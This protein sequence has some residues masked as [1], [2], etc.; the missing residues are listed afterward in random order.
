MGG[1]GLAAAYVSCRH[2]V[3]V[4]EVPNADARRLE[5]FSFNSG[6]NFFVSF[7]SS[8]SPAKPWHRCMRRHYLR[9]TVGTARQ[10]G[11][12]PFY[13]IFFFEIP[14]R[15]RLRTFVRDATQHRESRASLS[16][17]FVIRRGGD[18]VSSAPARRAT[19]VAHQA[20]RPSHAR[21]TKHSAKRAFSIGESILLRP[22]SG[23]SSSTHSR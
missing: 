1:V 2:V 8:F 17:T 23:A 10:P 20:S 9:Y 3:P 19:P 6:G 13:F 4:A 15:V 22:C 18:R 7:F 11:E 12:R 14:T 16:T 5:F 21:T